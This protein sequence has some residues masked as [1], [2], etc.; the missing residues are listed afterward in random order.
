ML[1]RAPAYSLKHQARNLVLAKFPSLHCTRN[2]VT[3]ESTLLGLAYSLVTSLQY[4]DFDLIRL[5]ALH[6]IRSHPSSMMTTATDTVRL[7]DS[8]HRF[9]PR[10][11]AYACLLLLVADSS[12]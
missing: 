7:T 11:T 10:A 8:I 5:A 3:S 2:H 9:I 6:H 4:A 12:D 1:Y